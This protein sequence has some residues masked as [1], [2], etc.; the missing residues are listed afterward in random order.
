MVFR[1]LNV[2]FIFI[3]ILSAAVQYNDPEPLRWI[4]IYL[5]AAIVSLLFA[6]DRITWKP[7]ALLCVIS[8]VWA[9]FIIPDLTTSGFRHIFSDVQMMQHGTEAAREFLGLLI[10][11]GWMMVLTGK[12]IN[13]KKKNRNV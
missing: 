5:A 12:L 4:V 11:A 10:V 8:V 1:Y 2:L 3:F 13:I 9:L 6:M 7:A